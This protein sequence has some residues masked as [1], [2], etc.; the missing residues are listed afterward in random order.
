MDDYGLIHYPWTA[1]LGIRDRNPEQ[2]KPG[3][4]GGIVRRWLPQPR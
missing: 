2:P 3:T 4:Y 1:L